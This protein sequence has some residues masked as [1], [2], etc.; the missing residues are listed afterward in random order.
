M[1]PKKSSKDDSN[2]SP[3]F[4]ILLVE[5]NLVNQKVLK[6][7]L[8]KAGCVVNVAN[9]GMEALTFLRTTALWADNKGSG[10]KL[11]IV[12]MDVEMPV[13]GGLA[14]VGRIRQM[15]E[16]GQLTRHVPVIAVTANARQ[17]QIESCMA[18]RMDDFVGKP[19][20]VPELI[21]KMEKVLA[22]LCI[23]PETEKLN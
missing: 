4:E 1:D 8:Q 16:E 7:Q 21:A 15:Q 12:L 19:F 23:L 3:L 22:D 13:M 9:H 14:C 17:A 20:R 10:K 18:A 5:D 11:D 6:R 2:T